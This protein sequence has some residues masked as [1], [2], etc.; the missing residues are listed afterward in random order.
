MHI[1]REKCGILTKV[2]LAQITKLTYND[3]FDSLVKLLIASEYLNDDLNGLRSFESLCN[4]AFP[5][6]PYTGINDKSLT[7]S[8]RLLGT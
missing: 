6:A 7:P 5:T 3:G 2:S 4:I 8:P 1:S